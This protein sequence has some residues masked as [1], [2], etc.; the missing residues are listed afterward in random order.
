MGLTETAVR[1]WV[2]AGRDRRRKSAKVLGTDILSVLSN[3]PR[4]CARR[5]AAHAARARHPEARNGFLRQGRPGE[6]VPVHT[7][8]R[9]LSVSN[10]RRACV[11]LEVSRAAYYELWPGRSLR[12]ASPADEALLAKIKRPSTP[13]AAA[14]MDPR[15]FMLSVRNDGQACGRKRVARLM[16][17]NSIVGRCKRRFRRTTIVLI[18]LRPRPPWIWSSAASSPMPTR[19][20]GCGAP[21]LPTSAPGKGVRSTLA[22]VIDV[23]SRRVVELG[24]GRPH[25]YRTRSATLYAWPSSHRRPDS[26]A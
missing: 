10:A 21:T 17:H 6:R 1:R 16:R 26:R 2:D 4:S 9:G 20:I 25:A 15:G 23:A 18:P 7:R 3:W 12:R 13:P 24:H 8:R 14:P 11:M 19:S 22:T 5:T